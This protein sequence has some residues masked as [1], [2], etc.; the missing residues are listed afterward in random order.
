MSP[1]VVRFGNQEKS[2]VKPKRFLSCDQFYCILLRKCMLCLNQAV[3]AEGMY[4]A[5]YDGGK[6]CQ[7]WLDLEGETVTFPEG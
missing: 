7:I 6:P 1:P 4:I 2:V 5:T 3:I